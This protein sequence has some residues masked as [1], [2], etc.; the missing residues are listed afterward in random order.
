LD[1]EIDAGKGEELN[2]MNEPV[3]SDA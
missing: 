2:C 3:C 1:Q